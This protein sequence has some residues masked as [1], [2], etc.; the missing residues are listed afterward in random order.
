MTNPIEGLD[1]GVVKQLLNV[2]ATF[3][4]LQMAADVIEKAQFD[5]DDVEGMQW[6][7]IELRAHTVARVLDAVEAVREELRHIDGLLLELAPVA[8][9]A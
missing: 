5:V 8:T 1:G 7:P 3:A 9:E 4:A 6:L 2:G